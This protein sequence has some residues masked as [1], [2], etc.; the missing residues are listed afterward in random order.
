MPS[1]IPQPRSIRSHHTGWLAMLFAVLYA[2]SAVAADAA[3][4]WASLSGE[5]QYI[6]AGFAPRWAKLDLLTRRNL[7]ARAAAQ[8]MKSRPAKAPSEMAADKTKT[9]DQKSSSFRSSRRRRSLSVAE[10][11]LSAHSM[12]LRR[13]L[14]DLPGLSVN[15]RRAL[16]ERWSSLTGSQRLL[17]VDRYMHNID[18]DDELTLQAALRE[19]NISNDDLA[20]GLA[21]G[22]LEASDVKDALASGSLSTSTLQDGVASHAIAAENL[23]RVM[24]D[25]NIQSDDLSNAIEHNR[26]PVDDTPTTLGPT[27]TSD[28]PVPLP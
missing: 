4:N 26:A 22:K 14:R 24:R 20:R 27:P 18:D 21:S 13:A 8:S 17:L 6:L 19:G 7:L 16:L 25:G 1:V 23:E 12:R 28:S 5:Q 10:A 3:L 9:A 15:E 11:G 2:S